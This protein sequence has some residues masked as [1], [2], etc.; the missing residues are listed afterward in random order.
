[1]GQRLS[2]R[3]IMD[4]WVATE[5][6]VRFQGILKFELDICDRSLLEELIVI[7]KAKFSQ[8]TID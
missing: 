2:Q 4:Q 7:E 6:V 8:N 3:E 5:N 1:M